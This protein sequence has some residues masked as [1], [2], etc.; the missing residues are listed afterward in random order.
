MAK[1]GMEFHKL[2][3]VLFPS[4]CMRIPDKSNAFKHLDASVGHG[5]YHVFTLQL[6]LITLSLDPTRQLRI[7]RVRMWNKTVTLGFLE[8]QK[9]IVKFAPLLLLVVSEARSSIVFI[10]EYSHSTS[11]LGWRW[12]NFTGL[13]TA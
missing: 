1:G 10:M 3:A 2:Q 6:V 7:L 9:Y 8:F 11:S 5:R 13:V 4:N 12:C